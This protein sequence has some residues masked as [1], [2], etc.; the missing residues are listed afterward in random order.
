MKPLQIITLFTIAFI[1]LSSNLKLS[2]LSEKDMQELEDI[3][4]VSSNIS[5]FCRNSNVRKVKGAQEYIIM[6]KKV[7]ANFTQK[8]AD[9][10]NDSSKSSDSK[11]DETLKVSRK[12][13]DEVYKI[14]KA[15]GTGSK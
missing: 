13:R 5:L 6:L 12:F 15:F 14:Y 7:K 3:K 9:I 2:K 10:E 4:K 1:A 11:L 8:L